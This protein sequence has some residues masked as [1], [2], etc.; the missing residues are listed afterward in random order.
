MLFLRLIWAVAHTLFAKIADLVAENLA[1]R[2]QLIVLHRKTRR[3]RLK[4][5][6]WRESLIVVET[7][8]VDL[9]L[10]SVEL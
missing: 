6:G 5:K 9:D 4:T 7:R 1:L 2:Q 10:V 8:V 3:P